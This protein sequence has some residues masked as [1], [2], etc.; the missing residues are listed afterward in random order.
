MVVG[1]AS[2]G[3]W[4]YLNLGDTS[5]TSLKHPHSGILLEPY[6]GLLHNNAFSGCDSCV[7]PYWPSWY[8]CTVSWSFSTD[9]WWSWVVIQSTVTTFLSTKMAS[10]IALLQCWSSTSS[11][12]F[13]NTFT[14]DSIYLSWEN[15]YIK[16]RYYRF[17]VPCAF[18]NV[19]V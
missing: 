12:S 13:I 11:L 5:Y 15:M 1:P 7:N 4:R 17:C 10:G 8:L 16:V 6:S 14:W 3:Q 18:L 19:F 9:D 2:V